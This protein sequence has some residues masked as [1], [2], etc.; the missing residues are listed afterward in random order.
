MSS[1]KQRENLY[2]I[3]FMGCGKSAV[4]RGFRSLYGMPVTEMD[5]QIEEQ[6]DMSVSEIFEKKGEACFRSLETALLETLSGQCG[7]V[8]S[9][10]GGGPLRRENVDLM[11]QGGRIVWLKA[12]P[13]TILERVSRDDRRPVLRGKKNIKDISALMEERRPAYEAAADITIETDGKS[14]QQICGEI[15]QE[16]GCGDCSGTGI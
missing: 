14:I 1:G 8:V 3:G 11:R 4:A 7:L 10:G 2:L 13:E 15:L 5:R 6:E 9:C 16:A 12:V